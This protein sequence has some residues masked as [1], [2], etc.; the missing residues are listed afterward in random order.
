MPT[1]QKKQA[2]NI[3]AMI[4]D[5]IDLLEYITEVLQKKYRIMLL[6]IIVASITFGLTFFDPR[7]F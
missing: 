5:E 7:T 1:L 3:A 2:E 6:S 4:D